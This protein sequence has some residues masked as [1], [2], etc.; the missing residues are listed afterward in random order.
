MERPGHRYNHF[1]AMKIS[2]KIIQTVMRYCDNDRDIIVPNL[3]VGFYEMDVA[4]ITKSQIVY[5][6]E[7]K[8]SLSDY[9]RDFKKI[10]HELMS[11]NKGQAN[12][13]YFVVPKDMIG[14]GDVP[15][16][17]GLMYFEE[18]PKRDWEEWRKRPVY[19][20]LQIVK[21]APFIHKQKPSSDFYSQLARK[22][23]FRERNLRSKI[24]FM[25]GEHERKI[26]K[27]KNKQHGENN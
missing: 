25:E 7:V 10:K 12:R 13:F 3:Y 2:N 6:Y 16:Y 14:L 1:E 15:A 11:G 8:I 5:E 27:L 18:Y 20:H 22:L 4:V 26:L 9:K 19:G 17:A 21:T 23:S 24:Y